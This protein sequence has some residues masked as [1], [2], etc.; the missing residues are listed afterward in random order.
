[1]HTPTIAVIGAGFS[2]TLLALHL[3]RSC[4]SSTRIQLIE[5]AEAFGPGQAYSTTHADHLLNVPAGRMSAFPDQPSH[6]LDWLRRLP[7]DVL[8]G[9][10]PEA[11]SFVPR[12]LYGRYL[13]DLLADSRATLPPHRLELVVG[14]VLGAAQDGSGLTLHLDQDRQLP[15]MLA[16]VAT[17]NNALAP[18][19]AMDPMLVRHGLYRHDPLAPDALTGLPAGAPVLLVGTGLTMVDTVVALLAAGHSGPI[20]ALSRRGLLPR[21]HLAAPAATVSLPETNAMPRRMR[22]LFRF[23]RAQSE[24][25]ERE[26]G[27]WRSMIDALRPIT[28]ALWQGWSQIEK[29]QFLAHARPW[30]DVHRHRMA[31]AIAT[32]IEAARA[33]GQL[34]VHAGRI[35]SLGCQGQEAVVSWQPR[36]AAS[37]ETLNV[38]RVINCTGPSSD[39]TRLA[40]PL[41]QSLLGNGLARPDPMRLGLDVT[42]DGALLATD[43]HASSRLFGIGPICRSALWEITAVPDIRQQCE[44]LALHIAG[45]LRDLDVPASWTPPAVARLPGLAA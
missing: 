24:R 11:G 17:G 12:H 14:K 23:V 36:G 34:M 31:P 27:S 37:S 35:T 18:L 26:G 20:H 4:P 19:P 28:Q 43:G 13:R 42:A 1:M 10:A 44:K 32:R 22:A 7:D 9:L 39:V 15:V 38:A 29:R 30:W 21:A 25:V 3:L 41:L 45:T 6:F 40:D 2:G 33:S 5:C 16:V 8:G